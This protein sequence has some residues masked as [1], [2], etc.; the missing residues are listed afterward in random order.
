MQCEVMEAKSTVLGAVVRR[1]ELGKPQSDVP[2]QRSHLPQATT[3]HKH[4]GRPFWDRPFVL[5][6]A[7]PGCLGPSGH[8]RSPW[9]GAGAER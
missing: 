9:V 1:R 8:R 2:A 6:G 4:S 3:K 5:P 7:V